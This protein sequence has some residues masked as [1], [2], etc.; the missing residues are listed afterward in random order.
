MMTSPALRCHFNQRCEEKQDDQQHQ[1]VM[2]LKVSS[3]RISHVR[4]I[5][6]IQTLFPFSPVKPVVD[7]CT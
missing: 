5:F 3:Y 7:I 4:L 1:H 6:T 2:Q